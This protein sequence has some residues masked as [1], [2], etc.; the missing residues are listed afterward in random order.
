MY[1]A[2]STGDDSQVDDLPGLARRES[3]IGGIELE[4]IVV[5]LHSVDPSRCLNTLL[6]EYGG[7]TFRLSL[8]GTAAAEPL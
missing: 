3:A 5:R 1:L 2:D 6:G 4:M 7:E 8:T